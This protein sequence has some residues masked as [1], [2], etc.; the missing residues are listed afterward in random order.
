ML[1]A[2]TR[3]DVE[4]AIREGLPRHAAERLVQHTMRGA[5]MLMAEVDESPE[6]LRSQV[7]SPG[8]TTAAAMHVLEERGFRA[9]IEDAVRAAAQRS[10]EMGEE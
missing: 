9:L 8:G 6:Y 4:A 3:R 1:I 2:K 7:T 5:G 10:G